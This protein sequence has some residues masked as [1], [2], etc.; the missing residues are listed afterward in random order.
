MI[1]ADSIRDLWARNLRFVV[2]D[3]QAWYVQSIN[4]D[5]SFVASSDLGSVLTF[6]WDDIDTEPP[7]SDP[8]TSAFWRKEERG[9]T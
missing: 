5:D 8:E 1:Q 3:T 7:I 2:I 9:L 6:D 4:D